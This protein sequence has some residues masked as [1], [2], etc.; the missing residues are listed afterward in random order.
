MDHDCNQDTILNSMSADIREIRSDVKNVLGRLPVVETE[1][2]QA[3]KWTSFIT[4]SFVSIFL[5][6]TLTVLS[7]AFTKK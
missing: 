5:S 1:C 4:S 2:K 7:I 6:V 3:A